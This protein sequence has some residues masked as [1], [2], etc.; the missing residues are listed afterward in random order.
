MEV[1]FVTNI[2]IIR[3]GNG[4]VWLIFNECI[5]RLGQRIFVR[6]LAFVATLLFLPEPSELEHMSVFAMILMGGLLYMIVEEIKKIRRVVNSKNKRLHNDGYKVEEVL[7]FL[8]N[9]SREHPGILDTDS[10]ISSYKAHLNGNKSFDPVICI[11]L[12]KPKSSSD[13]S[14]CTTI[15]P[16]AHDLFFSSHSMWW[17]PTVVSLCQI[18]ILMC[19]AWNSWYSNDKNISSCYQHQQR[20]CRQVTV[21]KHFFGSIEIFVTNAICAF[22]VT[23]KVIDDL[24]INTALDFARLEQTKWIRCLQSMSWYGGTIS[25]TSGLE[26]AV[27]FLAIVA[28]V[29]QLSRCTTVEESVRDFTAVLSVLEFNRLI[30][31]SLSLKAI[32]V[33]VGVTVHNNG[34][35]RRRT[36]AILVIFPAV[37][38]LL[39]CFLS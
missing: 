1:D 29:I 17:I 25:W 35:C 20:D 2:S 33:R 13:F 18:F 38:F 6:L 34:D 28:C 12:D 7:S 4:F 15:V 11:V 24:S 30:V 16:S 36:S 5:I 19:W 21:G 22:F 8:E 10:V 9:V 26:L 37:L 3:N 31:K 23:V 32:F 27:S 14:I 39:V